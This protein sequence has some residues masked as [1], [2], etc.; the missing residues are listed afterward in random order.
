M[1]ANAALTQQ[2]LQVASE[3][4]I[5]MMQD[6]YTKMTASCHKKCIPP[7]YHENDLTKGESVCIDRCVAKYF[8]IHDRVG[9]KLT[10][11]STQQAQLAET[12]PPPPS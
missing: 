1:N 3:I 4:E 8:E 11:L 9:K 2:Q 10:A 7:K 12:P 6:L 5:E